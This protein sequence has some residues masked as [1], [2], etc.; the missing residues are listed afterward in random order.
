MNNG[1]KLALCQLSTVHFKE[2]IPVRYDL[3]LDGLRYLE[4]VPPASPI[5][6]IHGQSDRTVPIEPARS[7][8]ADFPNSVRLIEV[9]AD[10]DLNGHLEFIWEY[11]QSSRK[12]GIASAEKH[13]LAMTLGVSPIMSSANA[14]WS[15]SQ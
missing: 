10:H 14:L 8:A 11:V 1:K 7:Y 9:D 5:I 13:R 4:P 15:S 3:H 12:S 6:I 2:E